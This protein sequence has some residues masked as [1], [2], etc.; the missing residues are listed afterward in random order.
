LHQL[1][2]EKSSLLLAVAWQWRWMMELD[3]L[4]HG[5]SDVPYMMAAQ[6]AKAAMCVL[7]HWLLQTK[8]TCAWL[9]SVCNVQHPY[10]AILA[11]V[12]IPLASRLLFDVFDL[13][14]LAGMCL[15]Q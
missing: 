3:G 14:L 13:Q 2:E 9:A 11:V 5:Q 10:V 8:H 6:P 4:H 12:V 15:W 7:C 1:L